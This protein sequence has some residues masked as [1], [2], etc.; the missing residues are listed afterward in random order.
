[1]NSWLGLYG[2]VSYYLKDAHL[3]DISHMFASVLQMHNELISPGTSVLWATLEELLDPE[4]GWW[5]WDCVNRKGR[6]LSG[7]H[8][9]GWLRHLGAVMTDW[10]ALF[11]LNSSFNIHDKRSPF[12]TFPGNN[13]KS[14][15][16]LLL[17]LLLLSTVSSASA[18][19]E[20]P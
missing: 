2:T 20:A 4:G 9:K 13:T 8:M 12:E 5:D 11:W 3:S 18:L 10:A 1:M 15:D 7:E 6:A 16:K 17:F 19:V 14:P